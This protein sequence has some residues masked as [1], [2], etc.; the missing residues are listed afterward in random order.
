MPT[1]NHHREPFDEGTLVKLSIFE[2]YARESLPVFFNRRDASEVHVFDFFA[3][4]GYD[5][6]GVPGTPI[7]ILHTIREHIDTIIENGIRVVIHLNEIDRE[8]FVEL[9]TAVVR[10]LDEQSGLAAAV[11][12]ILY[13]RDFESLFPELLP[14][15]D[16]HPSLVFV[17]QNGI[18]FLSS[19]YLLILSLMREVDILFFAAASYLWRFGDEP[20]FMRHIAVDLERLKAE[21]YEFVH[22]SLVR[23]LRERLPGQSRFRLYPFSIKKGANIYGVIFGASHDLAFDKYLRVAWK[24]D[25][26]GGEANFDINRESEKAQL[27]LFGRTPTKK[28]AFE[29]LVEA[30]VLNGEIRNNAEALQLCY[31]EGHPGGHA[32]EVLRRLR[33]QG[34][35]SFD[36]SRPR[37]TN[38][39]VRRKKNLLNYRILKP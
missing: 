25:N 32:A 11:E 20:D 3:G 1:R 33:T 34:R 16:K 13:Q 6:A 19:D 8:K 35:I 38:D 36:G 22:R 27:G 24:L 18:K 9:E 2:D 29:E 15:I 28:E 23:Q 39:Q 5:M 31:D 37:V 14:L 21:P 17:D 10:Y 26:L 7:R 4:P 30:K 12:A